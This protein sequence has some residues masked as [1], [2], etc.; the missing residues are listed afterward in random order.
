MALAFLIGHEIGHDYY[1]HTVKNEKTELSTKLTREIDADRFGYDFALTYLKFDY[2]TQDNRYGAHQF[3][4]IFVPL[5]ASEYFNEK[6]K[7]EISGGHPPIVTRIEDLKLNLKRDMDKTVFLETWKKISDLLK[8]I[9]FL[10]ENKKC[11]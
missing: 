5:I 6:N 1:G 11:E 7:M 9:D 8:M 2:K 4:G 3:A 10:P